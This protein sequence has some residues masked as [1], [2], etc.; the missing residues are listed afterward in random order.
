VIV[1]LKVLI[2][3]DGPRFFSWSEK[4]FAPL[5]HR[6]IYA[7]PWRRKRLQRDFS[8]MLA[9]LIDAGVPEAEAVTQ[10]AACTANRVF[11]ERASRAV[12]ELQNGMKLPDAIGLVDDTGDFHWR[13][14]NAMHGGGF[15]KAVAGWNESLDAK[16]FQLEQAYTQAITAGLVVVN[17]VLVGFIV[18][19]LFSVLIGIINQGVLW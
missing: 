5:A 16:A 2:Y 10:A 1:W 19:S 13:L 9:V 11:R 17:G 8:T 6:I 18:I 7:L 3:I 15:L 12:A 4:L 14:K